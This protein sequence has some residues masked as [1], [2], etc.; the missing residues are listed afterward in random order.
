MTATRQLRIRYGLTTVSSADS[1]TTAT[2]VNVHRIRRSSSDFEVSFSFLLS[3]VDGLASSFA[4]A[5]SAYE[6]AFSQR[7]Q[8][9]LVTTGASFATTLLDVNEQG[10]TTP[11]ATDIV[12]EINKPGSD[13]DTALSRLYEVT[14]RGNQTLTG[15]AS[16]DGLSDLT[17]DLT[18]DGSC[19]QTLTVRATAQTIL[20]GTATVNATSK[21]GIRAAAM[22][23]ALGGE[24]KLVRQDVI[25]VNMFESVATVEQEWV[26]SIFSDGA[27][28]VNDS[29]LK[30]VSLVIQRSR[31]G[32]MGSRDER[33]LATMTAEYSA[34][35]CHTETTDLDALYLELSPWIVANMKLAAPGSFFALIS[36]SPRF[37]RTAN[38]ISA[39]LVA[40]TSSGGNVI[41][42]ERTETLDVQHGAIYADVWQDSPLPIESETPTP[43][44]VWP[45][46]KVVEFT[47]T[48]RQVVIGGAQSVRPFAAGGHGGQPVGALPGAGGRGLFDL[49]GPFG[50]AFG[51]GAISAPGESFL[52]FL[53]PDGEGGGGG[54]GAGAGAGGQG[55]P[56]QTR[57]VLSTTQR[58]VKPGVRGIAP[59]QFDVTETTVTRTTRYVAGVS[60][61]AGSGGQPT[62]NRTRT[63]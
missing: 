5:A 49:S 17:H 47:E 19:V 10:S 56:G 32:A 55:Q 39:T 59:D 15:L 60:G 9:L 29:R 4:S 37:D 24:W 38:K 44:Y 1:Q 63:R 7:G 42:L 35:V 3:S 18:R 41:E 22:I 48:V 27:A 40:L 53:G 30:N 58:T 26:E 25:D 62:D 8:R 16:G 61:A 14:I 57:G 33:R 46:P 23:L 12:T 34:D 51:I 20:G 2:L 36:D 13:Y 11:V 45:G 50:T 52:Q 28:T 54:G 31:E 43:A 6:T 21:A